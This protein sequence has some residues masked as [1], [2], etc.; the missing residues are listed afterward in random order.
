MPAPITRAVPT[1]GRSAAEPGKH[2]ASSYA[3]AETATAAIPAQPRPHVT[4]GGRR[5]H[6]S[7]V[8]ASN[9]PSASS[10]AR[11]NAEKYATRG[12]TLVRWIDHVSEADAA[13]ATTAITQRRCRTAPQRDAPT[14]T[15]ESSAG[16]TR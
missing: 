13:I 7:A 4:R 2:V 6:D 1:D 9:A 14:S 15:R 10:H 11:V 3:A 5:L 8:A 16:H 12:N